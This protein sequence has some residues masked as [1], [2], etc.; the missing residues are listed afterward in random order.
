M[1]QLIKVGICVAYDWE[2]LRYS[3]PL[4]YE[5]ADQ[6]CLSLDVN[7][8]T[9]SG[10]P[11]SFDEVSFRNFI[12][13]IDR[14]NK[15]VILEESF[16]APDRTPM[17]NEVYQRNRMGS[18]LGQGGWHVQL[19]SDEYMLDFPG[20]V[21]YLRSLKSDRKL[22]VCCPWHTMFK[23]VDRGMLFVVNDEIEY[24]AVATRWPRYEYGRR[25]SNF[26]IKTN[27]LLVH[28]S[29]ARPMEEIRQ[30]LENWGH[31]DDFDT[32]KFFEQWCVLSEDN[33]MDWQDFHP[34]EPK[35]WRGLILVEGGNLQE[36]LTC[37]KQSPPY[38]V[39][40]WRLNWGNSVWRSRIF[41]LKSK[42]AKWIFPSS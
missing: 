38:Q 8:T 24:I 40:I 32:Q 3:L 21:K 29:W 25:N 31:R 23:K 30:K 12:G 6:I 28:Q 22:N 11:F 4:V 18:Y 9:W 26:N 2:Y 16:Y 19:D 35:T 27:F 34:I 10:N 1:N 15:I 5:E 13:E 41:S 7:R 33:F 17:Q 37:I 14:Q 36:I 42:I 20:F 39:P